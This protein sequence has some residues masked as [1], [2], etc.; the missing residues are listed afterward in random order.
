MN[1][2]IL[3]WN[4]KVLS[5]YK[6]WSDH[7]E[8]TLW[9]ST[10]W[11]IINHFNAILF[12]EFVRFIQ[13]DGDMVILNDLNASNQNSKWP[14]YIFLNVQVWKHFIL[15]LRILG[16]EGYCICFEWRGSYCKGYLQY[17]KPTPFICKHLDRSRYIYV[18]QYELLRLHSDLGTMSA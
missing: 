9:K 2:I 10:P 11:E 14:I 6:S 15:R 1:F 16:H 5:N 13:G 8:D 18:T 12:N 7:E 4:R 17:I 3:Y